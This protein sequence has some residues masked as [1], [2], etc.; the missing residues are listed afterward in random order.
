LELECIVS[1]HPVPNRDMWRVSNC[2]IWSRRPSDGIQT[3]LLSYKR[4]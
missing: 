4:T 1:R 2:R 3:T